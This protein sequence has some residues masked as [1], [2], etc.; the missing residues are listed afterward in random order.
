[1]DQIFFVAEIKKNGIWIS[2]GISSTDLQ[3]VNKKLILYL[4][5]HSFESR[6]IQKVPISSLKSKRRGCC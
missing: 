5:N 1:M 4:N 3:E 6:I 2:T